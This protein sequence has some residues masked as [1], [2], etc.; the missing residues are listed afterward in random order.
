MASER[1]DRVACCIAGGG[2]A[3]GVVGYLL[4]R[5][6]VETRV[7]EKHGDFLRDFRG[8]TVHPSTLDVIAEL[9][10]LDAFLARP[11]NELRE[12]RGQINGQV[13]SVAD[14]SHV[15][16]RCKFIALMP[17]WDFLNFFAEAG[18]A[19]PAFHLEMNAD[20]TDLIE[21]RGRIVGVRARTPDGPIDI[22]ATLVVGADGRSSRVREK[23]GLQVDDIGVP[24]DVLWM[25]LT[26]RSDNVAQPLGNIVNGRVF[27]ALDR[28]DYY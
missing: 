23:A 16:A 7:L 10:L 27:V 15:A 26:K 14:F 2:P 20:V 11:H 3:G 22:R 17:Q 5:A 6:G 21:E 18:H 8:D 4:A 24:I 1:A 28:G 13:V 12:I 19:L 9:G 25:R